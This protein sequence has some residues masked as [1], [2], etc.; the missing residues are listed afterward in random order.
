MNGELGPL[1][2]EARSI[3]EPKAVYSFVRVVDLNYDQV[4]LDNGHSLRSVVLGDILQVGQ[5]IVPYVITIGP[6]LE[7]RARERKNLLHAYLLEKIADH[8][9]EKAADYLRSHTGESL[10]PIVSTFSPGSGTGELFSIEQQE[11][12]FSILEP[13]K[14]VGVRLSSSCMMLPRKSVSGV[15]AA[16]QEDYVS[17]AYCPRKCESRR[18]PYKGNYKHSRITFE[19]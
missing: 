18:R 3:L 9:L 16:T 8:A 1:M 4:H 12:I 2:E 13:A 11:V 7:E 14:S 5:G 17:C 19:H 6:K 10:G 15:F